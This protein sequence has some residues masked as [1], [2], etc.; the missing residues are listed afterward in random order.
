MTNY[1]QEQR[2]TAFDIA[3]KY[4]F[5]GDCRWRF[6]DKRCV[7]CDCYQNAVKVIKDV[8]IGGEQK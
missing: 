6:E 7:E 1:T 4:G 2:K 5:C 3:I 8:L